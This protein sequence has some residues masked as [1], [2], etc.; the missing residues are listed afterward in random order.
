VPAAPRFLV[1]LVRKLPPFIG[2]SGFADGLE[3]A[4]LRLSPSALRIRSS[5]AGSNVD[6]TTFRIP[7]ADTGDARLVPARSRTRIWRNVASLDLLP[8]TGLQLRADLTSQRDL[9]DYGDSTT[10]ARVARLARRSLFG[11]DVGFESQ[12]T[13]GSFFGLTPQLAP[14][15]RPRTSLTTRFSLTRDPNGRTPIRE[16]GDSGGAFRLPTAFSNS[17]RLDLGTQV[18]L[19]RLGRGMFGDSARVA[20]WLARVTSLDLGFTRDRSSSFSGVPVTPTIGYQLAWVGFSGFLAQHGELAT[21][22]SYNTTGQASATVSFPLG[23]RLNSTYRRS[24][25]S[26]WLL[27]IANQVP[28]RNRTRE[29]PSGSLSWTFSPSQQTIGRWLTGLTAQFGVR[30]RRT[31]GEQPT[32]GGGSAN[33]RSIERSVSPSVSASWAHGVLTSFDVSRLRTEQL[34]AGNLFRTTRSQGNINLSFAWR[35][36]AALV[37][38]KSDIRTT[39]RY[40]YV[41]NT[42]CL[43]SAGQEA[44]ASYVDSRRTET[45][46]TLDTSFPPSL[47]A[48]LQMAYVLNDERQINRKVSQLVLTAFVQLN[49]SVGQVR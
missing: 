3:R 27:R 25:S 1:R 40:T 29:W 46:V 10:I 30:Q 18:D 34:T 36:P 43:Q 23:F 12:R 35:P 44:C 41:L 19:G 31:A 15:L 11:V 14:W 32:L 7:V 5:L 22:A 4:R 13:L 39:A 26:T 48:G 24:R 28:I 17:Q 38:L 9:R 6:R 2:R 47:N 42:S 33:T 20:R 16:Q 37:R 49:T 45:N 21:S 8:L